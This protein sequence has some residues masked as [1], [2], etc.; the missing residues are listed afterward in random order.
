[1][2]DVRFPR[3]TAKTETV[4]ARIPQDVA[5]S[6]P[7]FPTVLVRD[8]VAVQHLPPSFEYGQETPGPFFQLATEDKASVGDILR[9]TYRIGMP[10]FQDWQTR[11][12][13]SRLNEDSRLELRHVALNEEIKRLVVEVKVLKPFSPALLIPIA[14][15]AVLA[16]A[17]IWITTLSVERL[18]TIEIGE[19]KLKIGPLLV[20][21]GLIVGGLALFRRAT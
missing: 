15:V 19:T 4:L 20:I 2:S 14:I 9:I 18:G 3:L 12:M 11:F 13:V 1:M 16:G 8:E 10:F 7:A 17:L 5:V 21:G 6:G